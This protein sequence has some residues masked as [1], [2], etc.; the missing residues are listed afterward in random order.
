MHKFHKKMNIPEHLNKGFVKK[1]FTS[2]GI[3][4]YNIPTCIFFHIFASLQLI[5]L[6]RLIASLWGFRADTKI[7]HTAAGN[8]TLSL[9][10]R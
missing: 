3:Q 9:Y 8:T 6:P 7:T 4:T 10:I 2:T 5:I 1:F